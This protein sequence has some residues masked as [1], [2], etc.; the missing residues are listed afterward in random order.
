[1]SVKLDFPRRFGNSFSIPSAF[2]QKLRQERPQN[3]ELSEES[4]RGAQEVS[5][6]RV[7]STMGEL[8]RL[9]EEQNN[10]TA[11]AVLFVNQLK[12]SPRPCRMQSSPTHTV[13]TR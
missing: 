12:I 4:Q 10:C 1:M 2:A 6:D 3:S 11:E 13:N 7:P 9:F 5:I 8:F